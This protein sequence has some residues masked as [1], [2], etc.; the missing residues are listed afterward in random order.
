MNTKR[1]FLKI[2]NIKFIN[3]TIII[4]FILSLIPIIAVSFYTHPN[5]DDYN[6]SAPL[7]NYIKSGGDF[8]GSIRIIFER[9]HKSYMDWQGTFSSLIM[10]QIQPGIIS[11]NAYFITTFLM[12]GILILGEFQLFSTI[13]KL[14]FDSKKEANK[15]IFALIL[16]SKIQLIQY[17]FDSFYWYN[18]AVYYTFFYGL[19]LIMFALI[20]KL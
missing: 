8:F 5:Y 2:N 4:L 3:K 6:F 15:L 10:F 19:T 14:I 16:I 17:P 13:E 7:Y 9:V 1:I 20:I 18:G 11:Q 12:L